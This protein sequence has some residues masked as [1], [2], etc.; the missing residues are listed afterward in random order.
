MGVAFATIV[1]AVA[2]SVAK[3][4]GATLLAGLATHQLFGDKTQ[5]LVRELS[6]LNMGLMLP[7]LIYTRCSEGITAELAT[8]QLKDAFDDGWWEET[9]KEARER[10]CRWPGFYL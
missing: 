4:V 1:L 5:T 10:V 8:T 6:R 7:C 9:G 3:L 2:L